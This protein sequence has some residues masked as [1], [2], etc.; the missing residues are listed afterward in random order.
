[1]I[2]LE[3]LT[4]VYDKIRAV[5]DLTADIPDGEIFGLLGPNGAG[6]STTIL[7]L[8][9]LIEPTGGRCLINGLDTVRDPI[10][11]KQQVGYMPEDV[12]FYATLSA[13]EN[14]AYF[15][16]LYGMDHRTCRERIEELLDLV[17]LAGVAKTVGGYSKGMRQRLG[18]A[19][20]LLNDPKM[21]ILDEPTA[22][23]DPRGVADYR[24]IVTGIARAGTTV[25]VSSHI[26][27]EVSRVSTMVG[28][29]S[30]G[31][32]VAQGSWK[33]LA[34]DLAGKAGEPVTLHIET[35]DPMPEFSHPDIVDVGY[36]ADRC[37]A[38]I[39]ARSDI[40]D[41]VAEMLALH[42]VRIRGLSCEGMTL[43][44]TFLSYYR[45]AG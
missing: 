26:L 4:K 30:A 36:E 22:N 5:D 1:M 9:G 11:V 7:M 41:A 39:R 14:L 32:L 27:E 16:A 28:I 23:L 24:K 15:G 6:K 37:G 17:G 18:L 12:G 42:N 29:L 13:E 33:D 31:R 45:V 40:R 2:Q 20:A 8:V 35:R 3:H 25:V 43:E 10:A 38:V 34:A 44:E 19:K 21:I